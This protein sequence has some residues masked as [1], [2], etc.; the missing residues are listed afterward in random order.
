VE[1]RS[2]SGRVAVVAV[3]AVAAAFATI[4][5]GARPAHA[6]G[7]PTPQSWADVQAMVAQVPGATTADRR[8][9]LAP[10]A[11][12][13]A[14]PELH[15]LVTN[16]S[17]QVADALIAKLEQPGA[18]GGAAHTG[19]AAAVLPAPSPLG[20]FAYGNDSLPG[21]NSP[22]TRRRSPRRRAT[23]ACGN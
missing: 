17:G 19:H 4:G 21:Y 10:Q 9:A 3:V 23:S 1:R 5:G 14:H 6:D 7:G 18:H 12:L 15:D 11:A 8:V 22:A 2:L 16:G 20:P 13:A